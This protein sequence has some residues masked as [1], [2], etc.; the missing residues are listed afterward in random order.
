MV[1][2]VNGTVFIAS[3]EGIIVIPTTTDDEEERLAS[4]LAAL[5]I[6]PNPATNH[7]L[8]DLPAVPTED[9]TVRL[10][11]ASGSTVRTAMIR[12]PS[13]TLDVSTLPTGMYTVVVSTTK[14]RMGRPLVIQR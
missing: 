10:I 1:S 14:S 13:T 2:D 6:H 3:R 4:A 8:L 11:D 5:Q 7:V 12:T 9:V